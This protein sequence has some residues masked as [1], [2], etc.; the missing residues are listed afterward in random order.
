MSVKAICFDADGVIV[1]PQMQ[2]SRHLEKEYGIT[3]LMTKKFF[4]GVFN[5][6][7]IG[8]A[9]LLEVLPPFLKEWGWKGS[10]RDYIDTWL[11]YDHVIDERLITRIQELRHD[12][13]FCCLATSQEKNRANYMKLDM[14]FQK[15]FDQL[16]FSCEMGC[17]KPERSY[18]LDIENMLNLDPG[19]ILFWDDNGSNVDEARACGWKAEIYVSFEEFNI[20]LRKYNPR[21]NV[22]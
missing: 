20:T 7:L 12:G 1:N 4:Q 11:H 16:F 13:I 18:F 19:S 2:F 17:Q 21:S 15:A 14:G 22:K 9:D 5:E 6:C 3:P 8:K 10:A